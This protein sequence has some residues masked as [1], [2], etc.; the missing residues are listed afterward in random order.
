MSIT[1][2]SYASCGKVDSFQ[3]EGQKDFSAKI[4]F[5]DGT[6]IENINGTFSYRGGNFFDLSAL[7]SMASVA[8]ANNLDLCVDLE[9]KLVQLK[10]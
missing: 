1:S 2:L 5:E 6:S 4:V 9:N 7:S 10:K 3:I 8:L